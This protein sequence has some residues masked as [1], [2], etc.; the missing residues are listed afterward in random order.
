MQL[1]RRGSQWPSGHVNRGN[2]FEAHGE[3]FTVSA[4]RTDQARINLIISPKLQVDE[5]LARHSRR[6][7]SGR[8]QQLLWYADTASP[9]PT[10][11]ERGPGRA[12]RC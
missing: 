2:N 10:K 12:L 6:L 7:W 3:C 1:A 8:S 5:R 11:S 9:A 4:P